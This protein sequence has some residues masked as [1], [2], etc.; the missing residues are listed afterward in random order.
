MEP[1]T[2]ATCHM[3]GNLISK[4]LKLPKPKPA[5]KPQPKASSSGEHVQL[6][7]MV[8]DRKKGKKSRTFVGFAFFIACANMG[9]NLKFSCSQGFLAFAYTWKC[10]RGRGAL[11]PCARTCVSVIVCVARKLRPCPSYS[12]RRDRNNS[13]HWRSLYKG[14]GT[15][16]QDGKSYTRTDHQRNIPRWDGW[17]AMGCISGT[18]GTPQ[19]IS[20]ERKGRRITEV[21]SRR[22]CMWSSTR[23]SPNIH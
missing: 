2:D 21:S 12:G 16:R 20:P 1:W 9:V 15:G 5:P 13:V 6:F 14:G 19:H 18:P 17:G 11:I 7:R 22:R 3:Q 8:Y 23:I 4:N 10:G